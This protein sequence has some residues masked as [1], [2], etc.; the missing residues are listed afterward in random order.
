MSLTD[1][2][3]DRFRYVVRGPTRTHFIAENILRDPRGLLTV[4][5]AYALPLSAPSLRC[6]VGEFKRA[7]RISR[8]AG[9]GR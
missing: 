2:P 1:T 7:P 8:P 5:S 3:L 9:F 6:A 4:S